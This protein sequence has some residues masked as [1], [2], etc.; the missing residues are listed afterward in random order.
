MIPSYGGIERVTDLLTK[1]FLRRGHRITYLAA[2]PSPSPI[3]YSFP[4]AQLFLPEEGGFANSRNLE[5]YE[6]LLS[7]QSVD[8]VLNQ[9]GWAPFMNEALSIGGVKTISVIHS[10]PTGAHTMYMKE[11]L[12]HNDTF[13]GWW[14]YVCKLLVYPFYW[15][16]KYAKSKLGLVRH[17]RSLLKYTSAVVVLSSKCKQELENLT[18]SYRKRCDIVSIPNPNTYE[19]ISNDKIIKQNI[20]LYVGRLCENQKRPLRMLKVWEQL[21]K[22]HQDWKMIFVG[23]G[24]ALG[25]MKHYAN[26]RRID[27]VEFVGQVEDVESYYSKADFVCLTSDFEGWGMVLTEGM[28]YGCIPVTFDNYGAAREIIDDSISGCLIRPLRLR[29][30]ARRLAELMNST[31]LREQMSIEA[32][33]KVKRFSV[34]IIADSWERVFQD[35]VKD[36]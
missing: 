19:E 27:R 18:K 2:K 32:Q 28:R 10:T 8:V 14:R 12:R 26:K 4:T 1:E 23:D 30:Y 6:E 34:D 13:D 31:D 9:R 3:T 17:Y 11:I 33:K 35:L 25:S 21:Y 5:F 20:I 16:Y 22:S 29:E 7:E 36:E 15:T 24:D